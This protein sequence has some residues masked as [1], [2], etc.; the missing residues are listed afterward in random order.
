[1]QQLLNLIMP[2][3]SKHTPKVMKCQNNKDISKN[4]ET[5]N[6]VELQFL[7]EAVHLQLSIKCDIWS[8]KI[9][10]S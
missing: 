4:I 9:L 1:M 10:N 5:S 8:I 7:T 3:T 6:H 2:K